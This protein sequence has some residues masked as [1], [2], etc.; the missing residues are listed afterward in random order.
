[1]YK[2]CY[3]FRSA[4]TTSNIIDILT[5][6]RDYS[7]RVCGL[8]GIVFSFDNNELD[9]EAYS[10]NDGYGFEKISDYY[11]FLANAYV[12]HDIKVG[13]FID[14]IKRHDNLVTSVLGMYSCNIFIGN[15]IV[16][17]DYP[18]SETSLSAIDLMAQ[19]N[20]SYLLEV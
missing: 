8:D 17:F 3:W 4:I 16:S 19:N 9:I 7:I 2:F 11:E 13:D 10:F 14:I 18:D 5:P 12:Y 15:G 20:N 6:Y 1:M